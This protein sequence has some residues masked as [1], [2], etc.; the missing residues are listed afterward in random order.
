MKA[1]VFTFD[2]FTSL[3]FFVSVFTIWLLITNQL[4]EQASYSYE[5]NMLDKKLQRASDLLIRSK[6]LPEDWN[7]LNV[8]AF[9]LA[10]EEYIVSYDKVLNFFDMDIERIK[11]LLGFGG[12][13]LYIKVTN[14][15]GQDFPDGPLE[16]GTFPSSTAKI[17]SSIKRYFVLD[18][19]TKC[20]N[21][22]QTLFLD[23]QVYSPYPSIPKNYSARAFAPTGMHTTIILYD[24]NTQNPDIGKPFYFYQNPPNFNSVSLPTIPSDYYNA[25]LYLKNIGNA[26]GQVYVR[27]VYY[28]SS[29]VFR[30]ESPN[31][32]KN[33]DQSNTFNPGDERWEIFEWHSQKDSPVPPGGGLALEVWAYKSN[34]TLYFDGFNYPSNFTTP[35]VYPLCDQPPKRDLA[36]IQIIVWR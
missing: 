30:Y 20:E 2:I 13:N 22:T 8:K 27:I 16:K 35:V 6:G 28:N 36:V 25:S 1:Q 19:K 18:F 4:V 26:G 10:D 34:F 12:Y 3:I 7:G 11:N 15:S 31:Q 23:R 14:I 24:L 9:G 29:G 33:A 21:W 32:L 5:I 17:I